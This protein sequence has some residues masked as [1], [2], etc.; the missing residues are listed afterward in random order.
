MHDAHNFPRRFHASQRVG[1]VGCKII[2]APYNL[3]SLPIVSMPNTLGN[4]LP[5]QASQMPQPVSAHADLGSG[6]SPLGALGIL[7]PSVLSG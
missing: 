3:K 1:R 6:C 5:L 7:K 4:V 2:L